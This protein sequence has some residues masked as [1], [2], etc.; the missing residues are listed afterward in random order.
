VKKLITGAAIAALS[1]GTLVGTGYVADALIG[2]APTTHGITGVVNANPSCTKQIAS[3]KYTSAPSPGGCTITMP[4][5]AFT[6]NPVPVLSPVGGT[7]T[8]VVVSFSGGNWNVQYF[9]SA[10]GPMN[11]SMEKQT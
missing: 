9:M 3:T 11:F 1:L 8:G 2:A 5:A 10:P 7:L 4:G 6:V